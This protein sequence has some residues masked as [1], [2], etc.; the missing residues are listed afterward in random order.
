MSNGLLIESVGVAAAADIRDIILDAE[1]LCARLDVLDG[2]GPVALGV[3]GGSDSLALMHVMQ[4]WMQSRSTTS[5]ASSGPV[6]VLTVDHQL[7]DASGEEARRVGQWAGTLGFKH[8]TLVWHGTKPKS[9]LA[10][11]ARD[12]RYRLMTQWCVAHGAGRL[13][14]AHT[15]DD[16]AETVLMRL[17]RGS[18]VDGLSAMA[19]MT[20]LNGVAI[21]RP[22]LDVS[23][24]QLRQFLEGLGQRWIDDPSNE[25]KA[26][27]RVRVRA[28]LESLGSLGLTPQ[29]LALTA[30][31]L[32]RARSALD[33]MANRAMEDHIEAHRS[34]YCRIDKRLMREH[35]EEVVLRVL[36]R[37]LTA[38]GGTYYAPRQSALEDL[39][40]GL[41]G[42]DLKTR[43]LGGCQIMDDD[44]HIMIVRE[45]GRIAREPLALSPGERLVWDSRFKVGYD[46]DDA[47]LKPCTGLY[48]QPLQAQ[49]WAQMKQYGYRCPRPV[50]EGLVS[51]WCDKELV[52]VPHFDFRSDMLDQNV[53]ITA[54]FC[55]FPLLEGARTITD[56][57]PL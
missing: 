36:G 20:M 39:C 16:Q 21:V 35:P 22:F 45:P 49:G 46:L 5:D 27:E 18:G 55:N 29:R 26:Y 37:C 40:A 19:P 38:V 31:R 43:T 11:H 48:V 41:Q 47:V 57:S 13:L 30:R 1:Q 12:A 50:R 3:S 25:D 28:A 24:A 2:A 33:A 17:G 4:L 53:R 32:Q 9:G 7:R 6:T 10:A 54:D 56:S 23:R 44:G 15:L 52:A 34:G 51:F 42:G 14:I 8:A